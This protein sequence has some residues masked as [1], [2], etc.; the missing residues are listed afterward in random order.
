MWLRGVSLELLIGSQ[1]WC[2]KTSRHAVALR[3]HSP[4]PA[5]VSRCLRQLR[6]SCNSL[7][8][9]VARVAAAGI[10]R[11]VTPVGHVH[12][13]ET[14]MRRAPRL[15]WPHKPEISPLPGRLTVYRNCRN[16]CMRM[17]SWRC[18]RC[19]STARVARNLT[20]QLPS[21]SWNQ[22]HQHNQRRAGAHCGCRCGCLHGCMPT[23]SCQN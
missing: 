7:L 5:D 10:A 8:R 2:G 22:K 6:I 18:K 21:L 9:V 17:P 19:C 15:M 23:A 16:C 13:H 11:P 20:Y 14:K 1:V 12:R 4:Q 3:S